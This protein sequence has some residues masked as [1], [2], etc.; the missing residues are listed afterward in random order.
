LAITVTLILGITNGFVSAADY[1]NKPITLI[2]PQAP[3]GSTDVLG[4][5]FASVAEKH[6]GQPLVVVNKQG[7][8]G[9]LGYLETLRAAPDGYT[10]VVGGTA[11]IPL[12]EWERAN[13]RKPPFTRQD[14]IPVGFFNMSPT[15]LIV[16]YNSPWNSLFDLIKDCRAKP[17]HY[18]FCSGGLYG[19]THVPVEMLMRATG[20]TARHVPFVGGGPCVVSVTGGHTDFASQFPS[21]TIPLA[22]GKKLKILAIHDDKRL[23]FIPE[24]PTVKELGIDAVWHQSAGIW[25]V[26]NTPLPI[27]ER[28]T[29]TFRKVL[30]EK[31]FIDTIENFGDEVRPI[32]GDELVQYWDRVSERVAELYKQIVAEKK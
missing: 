17:N 22:R 12:I 18:A 27:V 3:G 6:L 14:L 10:I 5:A 4:R 2:V 13:G 25:A 24:V 20:I 29:A 30:Q 32:M 28:L 15:L 31:S 19:S 23:K 11:M 21:T 1:P 16:P 26:R 7:G 8:G 9:W